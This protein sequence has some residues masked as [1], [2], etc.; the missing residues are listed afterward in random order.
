MNSSAS[1]Y[2]M[3]STLQYENMNSNCVNCVANFVYSACIGRLHCVQQ[4]QRS[5]NYACA[6]VGSQENY[7]ENAVKP[8]LVKPDLVSLYLSNCTVVQVTYCSVILVYLSCKKKGEKT[9]F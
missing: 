2:L 6:V 9:A 8:W 1:S 3:C 7:F 4:G 5:N